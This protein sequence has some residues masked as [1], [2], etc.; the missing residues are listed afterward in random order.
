MLYSSPKRRSIA[1]VYPSRYVQER[2][3]PQKTRAG[4]VA[5][6]CGERAAQLPQSCINNQGVHPCRRDYAILLFRAL[7]S[8]IRLDSLSCRTTPPSKL[9]ATSCPGVCPGVATVTCFGGRQYRAGLS[10]TPNKLM[11]V[12][13][14]QGHT[15]RSSRMPPFQ[16]RGVGC[17]PVIPPA[18]I[19]FQ[20]SSLT[21]SDA[22]RTSRVRECE[23]ANTVPRG[24]SRARFGGRTS[25]RRP[26]A[27]LFSLNNQSCTASA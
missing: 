10:R 25:A 26:T 8:P 19:S 4:S 15:R 21:S 9:Y 3:R 23:S 1:P 22:L 6:P 2:H 20:Y 13:Y 12:G 17:K 18:G 11:H 14:A 5:E 7:T 16:P 24:Y 27:S